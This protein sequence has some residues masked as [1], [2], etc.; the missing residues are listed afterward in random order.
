MRLPHFA[1]RRLKDGPCGEAA[2]YIRIGIE[3]SPNEMLAD[4]SECG[5]MARPSA[6]RNSQ[7]PCQTIAPAWGP[8]RPPVAS[9]RSQI[10]EI[11][12]RAVIRSVGLTASALPASRGTLGRPGGEPSAPCVLR[13]ALFEE[14]GDAL[15][16]VLGRAQPRVRFALELERGVERRLGPAVQHH[17]QRA[18]R[19]RRLVRQ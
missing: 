1:C 15:R 12:R 18:E 19:E 4:P 9:E 7:G 11:F 6:S 16:V 8:E 10:L 17:L 2:V 3:T 14:R 5:G 13:G